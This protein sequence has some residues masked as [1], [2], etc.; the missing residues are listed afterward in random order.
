MTGLNYYFENCR[1]RII[2]AKLIRVKNTLVLLETNITVSCCLTLY[3]L[4]T[5]FKKYD[6]YKKKKVF[7][8]VISE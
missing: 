1:Q 3:M 8:V 5:Y 4:Y 6:S 7:S 2:L